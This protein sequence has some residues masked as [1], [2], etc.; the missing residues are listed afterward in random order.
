MKRR[1]CVLMC[2]LKVTTIIVINIF[3]IDKLLIHNNFFSKFQVHRYTFSYSDGPPSQGFV[4]PRL[5]KA[6]GAVRKHH[7]STASD[8]HAMS[9]QA[10]KTVTGA[11]P[12]PWVFADQS[13]A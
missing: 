10:S 6:I 9:R 8:R 3:E 7:K 13:P 11:C 2:K 4:L 5:D 12:V 1:L